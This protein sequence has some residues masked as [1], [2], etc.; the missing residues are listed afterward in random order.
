M[1]R[2]NLLGIETSNKIA[3]G[4]VVERPYSVVK[5][6]VENSI[7][8]NAKNITVEI[9]D[10]GQKTIKIIDDGEGIHPEDM[11][12]AFVPH[13]TSKIN[14]IEDIY[15]IDTMGFRGEALAS[16]AAV[17]KIILKSRTKEFEY[18][19]E[20][21]ISGG[22]IEYIRDTG[23][24]V[25]TTVEV[26]DL[27]YNVPARLKFL[28]SSSREAAYISDILDRLA[29]SNP[30][31]SFKFSS[32]NKRTLNTYGTG[33]L[34]DVIR[35]IYGKTIAENIMN[36]EKHSDIASVHGYIGNSEIS[37]GSRN[38][39]SIFVN[40]RYVKNKLIT[41]AVENA[42]KSFLTVN[43]FPFFIVFLDIFPEYIDINVHPTKS[44]IKFREDREIFK[45]TFSAIHEALRDYLKDSFSIP[46]EESTISKKEKS[47]KEFNSIQLPIDLNSFKEN[48]YKSVEFGNNKSCE[49]ISD[50]TADVYI[51]KELVK[52]DLLSNNSIG[53]V[54]NYKKEK[55]EVSSSS[56]NKGPNIAFN[57]DKAAKFP[58]LK[59][60][61]QF[62]STYILA[63]FMDNLYLIDQ[64][65]AHEKI[66][67]EKYKRSIQEN[68]VVSQVLITPTVM[69]LSPEEFEIYKENSETFRKLGFDID[70]FGD[71]TVSIREVPLILG[72]PDVKDLF[73]NLLDNLKNLGSGETWEVK[74]NTIAKRACKSAVKA[75]D[76]LSMIEMKSLME[77]LRYI[78]DP[79]TCPHG[80][81]TIIKFTLNELE[82]KFK[83]IQ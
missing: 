73:I 2:I 79:F 32:N 3:A 31:I 37:R 5:E 25:G 10:G 56:I 7:D 15:T 34:T 72:K 63:E 38:N 59:V 9:I 45:L 48:N 64:H 29:L 58:P 39:Q 21:S 44:E 49:F 53:E 55:D 83:R 60:I 6:L 30:N 80:R 28:K 8:S 20:I 54:N 70:V 35:N 14:N 46:E 24:N 51:K 68:N 47:E 33:K 81:P 61:G 62:H 78:D 41:A 42:F 4:E 75:N 26:N 52:E 50:T 27:F 22:K 18:G 1:K 77:D 65:A 11:E 16:I 23:C 17:S 19:K 43:K 57:E 69:E 71:N 66:L 36:F 82:K 74:Y 12:K 67:F 76:N 13:A 40:R